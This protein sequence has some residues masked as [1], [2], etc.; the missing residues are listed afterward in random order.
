MANTLGIVEKTLAEAR[1][2]LASP[3]LIGDRERWD[4][5]KTIRIS[6]AADNDVAEVDDDVSKMALFT[7]STLLAPW[8]L[9]KSKHGGQ[10]QS[11]GN[12]QAG[13]PVIFPV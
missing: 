13:D 2:A 1:D 4:Q 3:N 10:I 7:S 6:D 11:A 12:D 8:K 5:I 9:N